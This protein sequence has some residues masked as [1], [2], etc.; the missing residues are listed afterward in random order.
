MEVV[1]ELDAGGVYARTECWVPPD[2]TLEEL[3]DGLID[4]LLLL[5]ALADSPSPHCPQDQGEATYATSSR[6]TARDRL[7][8][9]GGRDPLPGCAGRAWFRSG[10]NASEGPPPTSRRKG[11][12]APGRRRVTSEHAGGE[13]CLVGAGDGPIAADRRPARGRAANPPTRVPTAPTGPTRRPP[14]LR[15]GRRS[16]HEREGRRQK[17]DLAGGRSS[18][19]RAACTLATGR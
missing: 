11:R 7:V 18:G 12:P 10:A 13:A 1:P 6:R 5:D 15:P 17:S 3:Q 9:P 8:P 19:V 14:P 16:G 4:P 2:V